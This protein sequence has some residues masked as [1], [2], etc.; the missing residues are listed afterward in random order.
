MEPL[1]DAVD[2]VRGSA[3]GRVIVEYGDYEMPVLAQAFRRNAP[4]DGSPRRQGNT[5]RPMTVVSLV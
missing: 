4:G 1:V 5:T 3:A 2:H